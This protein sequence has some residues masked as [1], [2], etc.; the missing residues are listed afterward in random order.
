MYTNWRRENKFSQ[1]NYA[2]I[3]NPDIILNSHGR[4]LVKICE[5]FK[6]Y[7]VNNLPKGNIR[8]IKEHRLIIAN[9]QGL[10]NYSLSFLV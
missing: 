6:C 7:I 3:P 10:R 9:R 8:V 1:R 4:E 5:S 2:Y